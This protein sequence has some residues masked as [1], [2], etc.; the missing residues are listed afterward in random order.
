MTRIFCVVLLVLSLL[1]PATG[2]AG[3][4]QIVRHGEEN[5][6][7]TVAK[8][9]FWGGVAGT[10][11]GLAILAA[12]DGEAEGS[13]RA[14]FAIGTVVGLG[15]GI[16]HVAKRPENPKAPCALLNVSPD[17]LTLRPPPVSLT[18]FGPNAPEGAE[19]SVQVSLLT[20]TR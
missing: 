1:V 8:S 9:T 17:G 11:V 5:G 19:R 7:M 18:G 4:P 14:S 15:Y 16:Y 2:F 3:E 13:F 12:S 10:M 20:I 6:M